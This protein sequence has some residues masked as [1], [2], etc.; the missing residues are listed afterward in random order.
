M[1]EGNYRLYSA[2]Y[3]SEAFDAL[4]ELACIAIL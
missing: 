2:Q 3:I 1:P 4:A